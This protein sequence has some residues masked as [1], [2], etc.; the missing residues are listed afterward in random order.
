MKLCKEKIKTTMKQD[1][2][3]QKFSVR[4]SELVAQTDNLRRNAL[5]YVTDINIANSILLA[6]DCDFELAEEDDKGDLSIKVE[7]FIVSHCCFREIVMA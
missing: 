6:T 4:D 2:L 5:H 3:L 7:N 1:Y